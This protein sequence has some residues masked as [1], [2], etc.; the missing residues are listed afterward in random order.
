VAWIRS[1]GQN[2]PERDP[3]GFAVSRP[4][5]M[6]PIRT[7]LPGARRESRHREPDP[8][9][10]LIGDACGLGANPR[11]RGGRETHLDCPVILD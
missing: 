8:N 9:F 4:H 6:G 10:P 3:P 5:V 2:D 11:K 1:P 7:E